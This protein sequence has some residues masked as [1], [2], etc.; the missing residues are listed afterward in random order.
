MSST[1]LPSRAWLKVSACDS[2]SQKVGFHQ[3]GKCYIHIQTNYRRV[4]IYMDDG[5]ILQVNF[6]FTGMVMI[7]FMNTDGQWVK[8][9]Q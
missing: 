8:L 7:E 9:D 6:Y 5:E 4:S 3:F 2:L 1:G